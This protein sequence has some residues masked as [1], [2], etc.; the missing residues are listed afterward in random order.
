MG[1]RSAYPTCPFPNPFKYFSTGISNLL[2]NA[3]HE[4]LIN[5]RTLSAIINSSHKD[6]MDTNP[7][8]YEAAT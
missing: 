6:V 5:L 1:I 4:I 8:R 2:D 3:H 7:H